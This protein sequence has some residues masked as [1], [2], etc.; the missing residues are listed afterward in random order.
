MAE[1]LQARDICPENPDVPLSV[2]VTELLLFP[3]MV[4]EEALRMPLKSAT[5]NGNEKEAVPPS[6]P[7]LMAS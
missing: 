7:A 3:G 2:A 6:R 4:R 5:V 1:A